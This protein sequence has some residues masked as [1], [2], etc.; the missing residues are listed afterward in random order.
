M[1]I[2]WT[3]IKNKQLFKKLNVL[4][5]SLCMQMF[6]SRGLFIRLIF[7]LCWWLQLL[8]R[9]TKN[10]LHNLLQKFVCQNFTI[11]DGHTCVLVK[12]S[13][14]LLFGNFWWTRSVRMWHHN[15]RT[16]E[17]DCLNCMWNLALPSCLSL[18]FV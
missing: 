5:L 14:Y 8:G 4:S 3:S 11:V 1:L 7:R 13:W 9:L 18:I 10:Y 16:M 17:M 2:N 12:C 15:I 6:L